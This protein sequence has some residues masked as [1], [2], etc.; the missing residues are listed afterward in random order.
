MLFRTLTPFGG[1][2]VL[3]GIKSSSIRLYFFPFGNS[4]SSSGISFAVGGI[5]VEKSMRSA[6]SSS[7]KS[8]RSGGGGGLG[9]CFSSYLVIHFYLLIILSS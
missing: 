4:S 7:P 9:G 1:T 5:S 3:V 8:I 2:E 6:G